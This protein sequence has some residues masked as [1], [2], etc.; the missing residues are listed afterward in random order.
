M[1]AQTTYRIPPLARIFKDKRH[2]TDHTAS[3]SSK[4]VESPA[5]DSF[6]V[7]MDKLGKGVGVVAIIL[8]I[9]TVAAQVARWTSG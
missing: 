1:N 5:K 8:G 4:K 6:V 7:L 2:Q 3:I 9:A